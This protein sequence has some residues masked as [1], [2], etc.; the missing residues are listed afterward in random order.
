MPP[1]LLVGINVKVAVEPI[2]LSLQH[3]EEA[4]RGY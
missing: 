1:P 3:L 2:F 4:P